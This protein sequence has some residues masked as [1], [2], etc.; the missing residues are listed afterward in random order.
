MKNNYYV[1][2][3]YPD[4][5]EFVTEVDWIKKRWYCEKGKPALSLYIAQARDLMKDMALNG[6][7]NAIVVES[8]SWV[9][10]S[11]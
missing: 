10:W 4:S 6:Q 2:I 7:Y 11:N 8:P 5:Y 3:L 9:G 1:A